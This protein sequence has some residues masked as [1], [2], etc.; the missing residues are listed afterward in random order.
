MA[1]ALV[2]ELRAILVLFFCGIVTKVRENSPR[3]SDG[4]LDTLYEIID[5]NATH[6]SS[7]V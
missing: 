2:R 3:P 6:L 1:A 4:Q 5:F 7:V